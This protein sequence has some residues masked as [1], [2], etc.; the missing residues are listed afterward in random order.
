[1][2]STYLSRPPNSTKLPAHTR[3]TFYTQKNKTKKT[4][5]Q[6]KCIYLDVGSLW[7]S[8]GLH[9]HRRKHARLRGAQNRIE[10]G[11]QHAHLQ[12]DYKKTNNNKPLFAL[13]LPCLLA[14][15]CRTA[16][17]PA[18]RTRQC[19]SESV[20]QQNWKQHHLKTKPNQ[21]KQFPLH[22][23]RSVRVAV[24]N[25]DVNRVAVGSARIQQSGSKN[26]NNRESCVFPSSFFHHIFLLCVS[27]LPVFLCCLG[28]GQ[29]VANG[30]DENVGQ[31]QTQ[32]HGRARRDGAARGNR[33]TERIQPAHQ[34]RHKET[35]KLVFLVLLPLALKCREVGDV[36][37]QRAEGAQ[38]RAGHQF[39]EAARTARTGLVRP[40]KHK[41]LK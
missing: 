9:G 24:A 3:S 1:V 27:V 2:R 29:L 34:T 40:L 37:V 23:K 30:V 11:R 16:L 26:N 10:L 31:G 36:F 35:K 4:Q 8:E 38:Q 14:P 13:S 39:A 18:P 20:S 15:R 28:R 21:T 25:A 32:M 17:V 6:R 7:H 19:R 41:Q 12:Q 33:K 22:A 5:P